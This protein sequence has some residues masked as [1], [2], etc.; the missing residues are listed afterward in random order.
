MTRVPMETETETGDPATKTSMTPA[1][2][3]P[4]NLLYSGD[5]QGAHGAFLAPGPE[6]P[7]DRPTPLPTMGLWEDLWLP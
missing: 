1:T 2:H 3:A 5:V 4:T 6:L 7:R